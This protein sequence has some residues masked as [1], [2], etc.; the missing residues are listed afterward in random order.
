[1]KTLVLQQKTW[2][3]ESKAKLERAISP[4]PSLE[5]PSSP[6]SSYS[7]GTYSPPAKRG[8]ISPSDLHKTRN[9]DE[10]EDEDGD[11]W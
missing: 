1:M 4:T 11:E 9:R 6:S 10:N 5:D 2:F 8:R 7:S 3:Q